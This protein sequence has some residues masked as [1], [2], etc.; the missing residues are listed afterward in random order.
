MKAVR[1]VR[2]NSKEVCCLFQAPL[3]AQTCGKALALR[4]RQQKLRIFRDSFAGSQGLAPGNRRPDC[5]DTQGL[6]QDRAWL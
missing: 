4:F 3:R 1:V 2:M 5:D 6:C